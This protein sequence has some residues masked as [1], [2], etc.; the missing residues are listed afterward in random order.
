MA[1]STAISTR[2][3]LRT[4]ME[5]MSPQFEMILP[6]HIPVE[7]FVRTV[8]TALNQNPDLMDANRQTLYAS[9]MR[10]AQFGLLPDGREAAL[11]AFNSKN[12]RTVTA[13]PMIAGILKMIR[14]SG[15][16]STIGAYVVCEGDKFTHWVDEDG[17]HFK[18]E[19]CEKQGKAQLLFAFARTKDGGVYFERMSLDD[20]EQVRQ[21]SRAKDNGPWKTWWHE[22]SKKTVIKRLAKRLPNS[23]DVEEMLRSDDDQ[24]EVEQVDRSSEPGQPSRLKSIIGA[25]TSGP[26]GELEYQEPQVI[27]REAGDDTDAIIDEQK[28]RR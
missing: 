21:C 27:E 25:A 9:A 7:K 18:Y 19:P 12:G 28:E 10:L 3:E 4:S 23:A 24:Y 15:E 8:L 6:K 17:E 5:R 2:D 16:L 26:V 11:V 20:I 22:M 14:N 13:M 1:K